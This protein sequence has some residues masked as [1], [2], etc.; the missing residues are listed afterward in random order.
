M[1]PTLQVLD[2]L[3]LT[4]SDP[5]R[6]VAF[7]SDVLGMRPEA[8]TGADGTRRMALK[9]GTQKIN[10]H[11]AGQEF[12]PKAARPMPGAADLCFLTGDDLLDWQAH[13][14]RAGVAVEAGPVAR[15]GATGPIRSLYL[16]DPDGNLIEIA[17]PD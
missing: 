16:R 10:L 17:T 6:T 9:F 2:H 12:A 11:K 4:V 8:F 3:V 15:T 1:T 7:Y 13:L 5:D 14:A